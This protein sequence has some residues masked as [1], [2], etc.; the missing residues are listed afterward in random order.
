MRLLAAPVLRRA[1]GALGASACLALGLASGQVTAKPDLMPFEASFA[2]TF[3]VAGD[4][5]RSVLFVV[6]ESGTG[7]TQASAAFNYTSSVLQNLARTPPGCGPSSSTGVD[8]FAV[9]SFGDGELTLKR[10][11]GTSCFAF[12]NITVEEQWII[13]GGTGAY[14]GATGA[15]WRRMTGDVRFGSASGSLTGAIRA[16][17]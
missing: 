14:A 6:Q 16:S 3:S 5:G 2:G 11:A 12:P 1:L 10:I 9:L 4:V 17:R 8:G 7:T 15:L 13:G